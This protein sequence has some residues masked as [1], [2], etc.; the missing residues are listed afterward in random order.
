M[1][2]DLGPLCPWRRTNLAGIDKLTQQA[3][4]VGNGV[5][6]NGKV[7]RLDGAERS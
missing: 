7:A 2:G 6:R 3:L 1:G 5:L 4:S